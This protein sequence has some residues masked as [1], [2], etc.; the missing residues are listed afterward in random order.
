MHTAIVEHAKTC[1]A[2]RT[3]IAGALESYA[4]ELG[5][6]VD[7]VIIGALQVVAEDYTKATGDGMIPCLH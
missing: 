5:V 7:F 1:L 6:S 4:A 3:D 2:S